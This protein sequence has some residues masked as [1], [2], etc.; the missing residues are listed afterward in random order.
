[1]N[2][3]KEFF[4]K[5]FMGGFHRRD[6]VAYIVKLSEERNE[7]AAVAE[8]A[9]QDV[10]TLTAETA[11]L[12]LELEEVRKL[13]EDYKAEAIEA[14][15]KVLNKLEELFEQ[16]RA[17]VERAAANACTELNAAAAAVAGVPA[18]LDKACDRLSIMK[19]ELDAGNIIGS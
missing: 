1:M 16:S 7:I 9:M 5:S 2:G 3:E 17:D 14:A 6:V 4:R 15:G 10:R 11:A 12:R 19:S 13:A 8:K 18:V